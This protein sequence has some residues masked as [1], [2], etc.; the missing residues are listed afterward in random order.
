MLIEKEYTKIENKICR[1]IDEEIKLDLYFCIYVSKLICFS[2]I[3]NARIQIHFKFNKTLK[4]ISILNLIN[5]DD[6]KA[7]PM[8]NILK[9]ILDH[10]CAWQPAT[11]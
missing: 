2:L 3:C 10:S 4:D 6:Y 5:R 1:Y 7:T 8:G 9:R 11:G